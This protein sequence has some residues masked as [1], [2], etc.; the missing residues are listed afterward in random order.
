[1]IGKPASS[2]MPVTQE[3][4]S[5]DFEGTLTLPERFSKEQFCNE[6]LREGLVLLINQQLLNENLAIS[7]TDVSAKIAMGHPLD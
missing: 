5:S 6:N 7:A 2:A 3:E 1:M 4:S